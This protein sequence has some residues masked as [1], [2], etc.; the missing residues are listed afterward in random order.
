MHFA[1]EIGDSAI[2]CYTICGQTNCW[3]NRGGGRGGAAAGPASV[4]HR[5]PIPADLPGCR[6]CTDRNSLR[7]SSSL[8]I[9]KSMAG[10]VEARI[11]LLTAT[12]QARW[13]ARNAAY[14]A[15]RSQ[16]R[17]MKHNTTSGYVDMMVGNTCNPT[18]VTRDLWWSHRS[19]CVARSPV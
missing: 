3:I 9:D 7:S 16:K 5:E 12:H 4:L 17:Q 18:V 1:H 15:H 11:R 19:T 10:V 6:S 13:V 2:C 14:K 8:V